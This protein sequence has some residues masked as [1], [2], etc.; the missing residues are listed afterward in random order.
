M[1]DT[2]VRAATDVRKDQLQIGLASRMPDYSRQLETGQRAISD[3]FES[4]G[5]HSSGVRAER[6]N[7]QAGDVQ[8]KVF[9]DMLGVQG[10]SGQLDLELA[11]QI[12][13]N[14]RQ[15]AESYLSSSASTA[16][17]N[18]KGVLNPLIGA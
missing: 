12:A 18:A 11:K 14:R 4:R 13:A 3:D 9:Q 7:E 5:V 16:T 1:S 2:E 6:Q 10:D 8:R 17:G 15:S